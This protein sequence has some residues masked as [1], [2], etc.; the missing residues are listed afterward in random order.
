[1]KKIIF[2]TAIALASLHI[3]AQTTA[4]DSIKATINRFF[5]GMKTVDT[6]VIRSTLTEGVIFQTISRTKEGATVVKTENVNDFLVSIAKTEKGIL[7]ERITFKTVEFDGALGS[8]WTPY[9]FYYKGQFAHCGANSFQVVK[10]EGE[11]R[12]QYIIDTRRKKGCE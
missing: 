6:S 2:T 9:Q 8:V 5:E 12:I 3:T 11:W 4:T 1:M 10:V 7:D